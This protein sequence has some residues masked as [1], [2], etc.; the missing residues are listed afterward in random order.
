[1]PVYSLATALWPNGVPFEQVIAELAGAGFTQCELF[2][3]KDLAD[4]QTAGDRRRILNRHGVW[5][6]TIHSDLGVDLAALD[7]H[8]RTQAVATVASCFEPFAEL[9][10]FA[11][12]VHPSRGDSPAEH[13][14][15]RIDAL[16]R[17]L[18]TLLSQS[19]PLGIRL[20]CENLQHKGEPRPLCRMED[21]RRVIDDYPPSVGICLD[22]G[23]ANNNGLDPADEARIAGER[24]IALHLQDT[25]AVEDR[26]WPPGLG[27]INWRR[28]SAALT[29]IGFD[30]AWTFEVGTGASGPAATAALVRRI[31]DAWAEGRAPSKLPLTETAAGFD[32]L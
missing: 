32:A 14:E 8:V 9:G 25:D 31:A 12:I 10:G 28:V 26:H 22:T 24:L 11:V 6:R 4:D 3:P 2:G 19:E 1:M 18:D 16:R 27:N 13:L 5:P 30:G 20:A 29:E 21:L 7:D 15:P 17:S 23:H